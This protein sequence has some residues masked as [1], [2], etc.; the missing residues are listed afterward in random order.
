MY[1]TKPGFYLMVGPDWKGD[2]PNGITAVYRAKTQTG[3]VVPRVFQD[4]TPEDKQAVQP[5]INQI[6][7]YPLSEFD[8]KL[9]TQDWKNIKR[10]PSEAS[11]S[12]ET[13]WV[14]PEKFFDE[15]PAVLNDAKPLPGEQARYAE[16]LAVIAAAQKDPAISKALRDEAIKAD[17]DLVNPLLQFRN[18]GLPLPGNWTTVSNGAAFGTDYFTRT[19]VARSNILV[20]KPAETKY[21][22]QDLDATGVRLNGNQRYTVTFAAGQL[23]PVK[24]FWSLTMYDEHHMFVPNTMKRF[25]LGTKNKDL[26]TNSDGSLTLYVGA[27]A[28]ADPAQRANWLPAPKNGDFSLYIRAYWPEQTVINGQWTPPAVEKR[29]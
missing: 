26:K 18:Y 11:G 16:V 20:N 15:L 14:F 21:F 12:G 27:D 8:G 6:N 13:R 7:V 3:F 5:I 25:S 28:P 22:Y 24:G 9:K 17:K 4:D 2:V 10:F 29:Q 23:P 19:A 1:G